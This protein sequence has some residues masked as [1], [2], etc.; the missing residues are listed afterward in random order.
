[1]I[2]SALSLMVSYSERA[3]IWLH[4]PSNLSEII[5]EE[6]DEENTTCKGCNEE[7]ET[8]RCREIMD[9]FHSLNGKLYVLIMFIL[10]GVCH[11]D[12]RN[13]YSILVTK[14]IGQG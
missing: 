14:V 3:D 8:C 11:F 7:T 1:M 10:S 6:D 9:K 5:A 4:Y 12:S 2:V 13:L